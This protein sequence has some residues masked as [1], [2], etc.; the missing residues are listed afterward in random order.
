MFRRLPVVYAMH[1]HI[2]QIEDWRH[3]FFVGYFGPIGVSGIF[4]LYVSLQ[5]LNTNVVFEGQQRDD[6]VRLQE[7]LLVVVW[8]MVVCSVIGHGLS[9]P[10]GKLG[11][12]LPRTLSR[13]ISTDSLNQSRFG[14]P[15]STSSGPSFNAQTSGDGSPTNT[16]FPAPL[17]RAGRSLVSGMKS[18]TGSVVNSA[19]TTRGPTPRQT[20]PERKSAAH[21]SGGSDVSSQERGHRHD[22]M[23]SMRASQNASP[24]SSLMRIPPDNRP[25][26]QDGVAWTR[27][28]RFPDEPEATHNRSRPMLVSSPLSQGGSSQGDDIETTTQSD[29]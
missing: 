27:S 22:M 10:L 21:G 7:I 25:S 19:R 17:W 14:L 20:S 29:V 12:Y 5:W 24:T 13:A 3:C 18:Q 9:I 15:I 4:Y 11:L 1:K 28:I 23:S 2:R 6:A 16:T 8:F 26:S